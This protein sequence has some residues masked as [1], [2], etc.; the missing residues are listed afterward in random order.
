[1]YS[2]VVSP[3]FLEQRGVISSARSALFL[4]E[5]GMYPYFAMEVKKQ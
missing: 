5:I 3:K 2:L 1:M 4:I